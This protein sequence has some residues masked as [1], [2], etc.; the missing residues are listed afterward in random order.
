MICSCS[1]RTVRYTEKEPP[2]TLRFESCPACGRCDRFVLLEGGS[3]VLVGEA[4]RRSFFCHRRSAQAEELR[5]NRTAGGNKWAPRRN[6]SAVS[7]KDS[8]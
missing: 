6:P 8:R 2:V 1:C 5:L 7:G 3:T 4:A